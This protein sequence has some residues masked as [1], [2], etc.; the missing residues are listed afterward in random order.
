MFLLV[1]ATLLIASSAV[2]LVPQAERLIVSSAT[3]IIKIYF[4][5][6]FMISPFFVKK[7]INYIFIL[8]NLFYKHILT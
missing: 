1:S 6:D 2:T 7:F 3:A 5:I 8:Y 4:F